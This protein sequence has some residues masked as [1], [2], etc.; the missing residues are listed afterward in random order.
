VLQRCLAK[1]RDRRPRDADEMDRLLAAIEPTLQRAPGAPPPP[2]AVE[3]KGPLSSP[4]SFLAALPPESV[5]SGETLVPGSAATT[6]PERPGALEAA[7]ILASGAGRM[8]AAAATVA[9]G[10]L[11][12][13]GAMTGAVPRP[14]RARGLL[15]AV[16]AIV[17]VSMIG[18][19]LGIALTRP[20]GRARVAS[21]PAPTAT[22]AGTA[23]AADAI[24]APATT[25]AAPAPADAAPAPADARPIPPRPR[26]DAGIRAPA[27]D[28]RK[29][30]EHLEAAEAA[31]RAGNPIGYLYWAEAALQ[32][33]RTSTRARL[34][35][36]DALLMTGSKARGCA[37]LRS[38]RRLPAAQAKARDAGCPTD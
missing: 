32:A 6:A 19:A 37:Q 18:V 13:P 14:R 21:A 28:A 5:A 31:L 3:M 8:P 16:G 20:P 2:A 36:A 15:L 7:A 38:L 35:Y 23:D 26:A 11:P 4:S 34:M 25:D 1:Q 22:D 12:A 30:Q 17:V 10:T 29:L 33:D 24:P 9:P 27:P